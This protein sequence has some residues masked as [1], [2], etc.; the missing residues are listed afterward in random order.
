[1]NSVPNRSSQNNV[2]ERKKVVFVPTIT[3]CLE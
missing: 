3:F 1:M 2:I